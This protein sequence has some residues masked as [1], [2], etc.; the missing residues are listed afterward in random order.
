M[1]AGSPSHLFADFQEI[2]QNSET[3]GKF[4]GSVTRLVDSFVFH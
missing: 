1:L 3:S 2:S 4:P